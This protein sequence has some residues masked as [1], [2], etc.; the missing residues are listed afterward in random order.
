MVPEHKIDLVVLEGDSGSVLAFGPGH[1]AMSPLPGQPGNS[2]ISGHRDTSFKFL[3]NIRKD[4]II[5][6]Q[7]SKGNT[8]LFRVTGTQIIDV[9][10]LDIP[11]NNDLACL[12]L[13]TCYPFNA[14]VPGGPQR[15]LVFA[16]YIESVSDPKS[17]VI[18][19]R[20][21]SYYLIDCGS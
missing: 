20:I 4:E 8:V 9:A 1:M 7:T 14:V 13:V 18:A 10:D 16:E 3:Q 21:A 19:T 12:T 6:I 17:R 15:Y 11:F 2:I 5:K